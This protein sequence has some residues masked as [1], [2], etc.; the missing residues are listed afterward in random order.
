M[1]IMRLSV[2]T[3]TPVRAFPGAEGFGRDS[4]GGRG[5]TVIFVTNL[6]DS[7]AG[8]FREAL[9]TSGA[10]IIVFQVSG[11]I[12]LTSGGILVSDPYVTIA[13]QTSPGGICTA[14][15]TVTFNTH[16]VTVRHMRF[17]VGSSQTI[18]NG[19]SASPETLDSV[20]IF[21]D[22]FGNDAYNI[23]FDHCSVSWGIDENFSITYR[24]HDITVQRCMVAEAL[25]DAGHPNGFHSKGLLVSGKFGGGGCTNV[26]LIENFFVNNSDRNPRI[27]GPEGGNH[28][29]RNNVSYN[30]SK[31]GAIVVGDTVSLNIIHNFCKHGPNTLLSSNVI[32]INYWDGPPTSNNLIYLEGNISP[33][34]LTHSDPQWIIADGGGPTILTTDYQAASAYTVPSIDTTTAS[35]AMAAAII[36]DVGANMPSQDSVDARNV[37]SYNNETDGMV[38]DVIYPDDYPALSG[39]SVPTDTDGDGI[40][41]SYETAQ[42]YTTTSMNPNDLA[43][44]GYTWIE[45]YINSI[46]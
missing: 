39:G 10:R 31:G 27:A 28:D 21:G 9:Q 24:S 26:S 19:G 40:P 18:A 44:S 29:V 46:A 3:P 1:A 43:P 17:R 32:D 37:T 45:E 6:N 30:Y 12:L 36:A 25:W 41:D 42:G 23:I 4:I 2:T 11:T 16:D 8:S 35:T 14:G 22:Q 13:G 7:G 15:Y 38:D 33:S 20:R 5:G 34:R